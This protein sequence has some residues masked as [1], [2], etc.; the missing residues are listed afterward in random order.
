MYT[1]RQ[2]HSVAVELR[3]RL[4]QKFYKGLCES[5]ECLWAG[6]RHLPPAQQQVSAGCFDH[7][8]GK[9]SATN[10]IRASVHRCCHA[11]T[12]CAEPCDC[13]R[14]C[15]HVAGHVAHHGQNAKQVRSKGVATKAHQ[16]WR[17]GALQSL[18]SWWHWHEFLRQC[19]WAGGR[20]E[21]MAA[22][23]PSATVKAKVACARM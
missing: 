7:A 19:R 12:S 18:L 11:C 17:R 9:A 2:N 6:Q 21:L 13:M 23:R 8:P 20:I 15:V 16:R 10:F 5:L 1:H 14:C 3:L 4:H 22:A